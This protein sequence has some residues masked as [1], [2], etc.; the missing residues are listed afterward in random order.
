M[1]QSPIRAAE[2][3]NVTDGELARRAA[4]GEEA[5]FAVIMRRHNQRLFRTA[6]SI[7]KSDAEAEDALQEAYLRAWQA[8]SKFRADAA[9]STWLVRIVA[10]EALGRLR[11]KHLPVTSL[12]NVMNG[13]KTEHEAALADDPRHGP[14]H[15]AARAQLRKRVE[16]CID[17]LPEDFRTVFMLR[18]V[19]GVSAEEVA[20]SLDLPAATVRTRYFRA[21][22]LMREALAGDIDQAFADAFG[23]DGE[24]CDRIVANVLAR[25][26]AAGLSR[27]GDADAT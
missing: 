6:R 21:R 24:R 26:R 7:L 19:E 23:F 25:G 18:A 17:D 15:M 2:T 4:D 27:G 11:R 1:Q 10:N 22:R 5:A 8:M 9:L 3:A 14:Q 16:S 12:D 20:R 13:H